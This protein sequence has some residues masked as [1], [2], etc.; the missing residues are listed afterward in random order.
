MN[1]RN[2]QGKS[3]RLF[4][5]AFLEKFTHVHPITPVL[6]WGPFIGFSFWKMFSVLK[7]DIL[8]ILV[9]GLAGFLCW[10]LVEYLMHRFVF[11]FKPLGPWSDRLVFLFHGI[12]HADP[13][14]L[15]RLVLP[16]I[17]SIFFSS[18]FYGLFRALMGP[19][20]V[21]PFF[22]FFIMGY[23]CYD[24]IHYFSHRFQ[25][26]TAFGKYLKQNHMMHHFVCPDAKWGVSSPLWDFIFGTYVPNSQGHLQTEKGP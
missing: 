5:S 14:D 11:H 9:V 21:V 22:T 6:L 16:P 13:E 3:I 17:V 2:T 10:T 7:L 23:L 12:H 8:S 19:V 26:K 1:R 15:S 4:N 24:Y 18:I 25:P 20:W